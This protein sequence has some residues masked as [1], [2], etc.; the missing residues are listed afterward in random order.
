M[1]RDQELDEVYTQA[2]YTMTALGE[3]RTPLFLARLAL[4]LMKEVGDANRIRAVIE[5]ARD[6]VEAG[7]PPST[8][9]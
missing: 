2:C 7:Q 3:Q 8:R 4:V 6:F 1:L 5:A 9:L